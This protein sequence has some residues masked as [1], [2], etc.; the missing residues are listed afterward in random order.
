MNINAIVLVFSVLGLMSEIG[1]GQ[2]STMA[3]KNDKDDVRFEAFGPELRQ[4][5]LS[6]KTFSP[7]GSTYVGYYRDGWDEVISVHDSK[8][9]KQLRRFLCHG[10]QEFLFTPDGRTLASRCMKKGWALWDV[11]SGKLL[12]RLPLPKADP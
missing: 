12:L 11:C 8:T 5:K 3:T 10:D 7:D 6:H 2:R 1:L 9:Q 4:V